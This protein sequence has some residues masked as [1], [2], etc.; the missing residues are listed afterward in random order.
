MELEWRTSFL[1]SSRW[2]LLLQGWSP[3]SLWLGGCSGEGPYAGNSL[4]AFLF[5]PK[6]AGQAK[7][8]CHPGSEP[9]S[10]GFG[11]PVQA[12]AQAPFLSGISWAVSMPRL[13]CPT[14]GRTQTLE[15]RGEL[16]ASSTPACG[17]GSSPL[18]TGPQAL[19]A[20]ESR[21]LTLAS[22]H[23]APQVSLSSS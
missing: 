19:L 22:Q 1:T 16:C 9:P 11:S 21:L 14:A 17:L 7:P 3:Q 15:V 4:L 20:T 23:N 10:P 8:Q 5:F 2:S 12:L 6:R 13:L 18:P